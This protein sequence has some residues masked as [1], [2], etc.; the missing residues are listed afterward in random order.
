MPPEPKVAKY[1]PKAARP[2]ALDQQLCCV[3]L[4][5]D[6]RLLAAGSFEGTIRRWDTT[7]S[8]FAELPVLRGHDG[9]VQA[10]AF[11][12]DGRRLFAA[13]SWGRLTCWPAG[14]K[15]AKPLWTVAGAHDGWI[16]ALA[17]SPDG[18]TVATGGRD[19]TVRITSANDGKPVRTLAAGEDVLALA[20]HP[21]GTALVTGDLKG[22]VKE[23]DPAGGKVAREMDAKVMFLR[24]RIQD[25]GGVRCFAFG[26]GG[27][28]LFAGGTQP[29]TG[30]FVQGFPLILAFDWKAGSGKPVY[31]GANDNEGF[32]L[33]LHW[34]ADGFLAAVTS[35]Q[36]GQGKLLFLRPDE[37]QPFFAQALPNL[38]SLTVHGR[39][40]VVSATNANSS[41]NGRVIGKDKTEYPGNHSP[42]HVFELPG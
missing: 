26:P 22:S 34:H 18:K 39:R 4:S 30:A 19:R 21:N 41:G 1:Q 28:T 31:K 20:F 32:A 27:A 7:A 2:V 5:P 17:V 24:D 3:R 29:K 36:P 33:D 15:D 40:V 10:V 23:W 42:L 9:W 11:H 35:G 16:H 14:E 6:G 12:Q 37:P 25:V 38:H 13:D 8:P